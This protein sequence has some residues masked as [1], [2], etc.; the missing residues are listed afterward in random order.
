MDHG[1]NDEK[2]DV[3]VRL[4]RRETSGSHFTSSV[5]NSSRKRPRGGV[6]SNACDTKASFKSM[7]KLTSEP[8][9][10][11]SAMSPRGHAVR[12]QQTARLVSEYCDRPT[13][14][15]ETSLD[16]N[17]RLPPPTSAH[18]QQDRLEVN[19]E[20]AR[21]DVC[22]IREDTS[23]V[24]IS[25]RNND[26]GYIN[27]NQCK[28]NS[29]KQ[30]ELIEW[31]SPLKKTTTSS[32]I[33]SRKFAN[34]SYASSFTSDY[35]SSVSSQQNSPVANQNNYRNKI[36]LITDQSGSSNIYKNPIYYDG[37]KLSDVNGVQDGKCNL[38]VDYEHNKY[39][40]NRTRIATEL[41]SVSQRGSMMSSNNSQQ[42]QPVSIH[43][44]QENSCSIQ[45][46]STGHSK[47]LTEFKQFES[48]AEETNPLKLR[49]EIEGKLGDPKMNIVAQSNTR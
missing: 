12:C 30:G 39:K 7:R 24:S 37:D 10:D 20:T 29:D 21:N 34:N 46:D 49:E 3:V 32:H 27:H 9:A 23:I 16:I 11:D 33:S 8:S 31:C 41:N 45:R 1:K 36:D 5:I 17:T 26:V 43:D 18:E 44:Y 38:L 22:P 25:A 4:L 2:E 15:R 48:F 28:S 19:Q 40:K 35:F 13:L 6:S 42:Q 14:T 47:T